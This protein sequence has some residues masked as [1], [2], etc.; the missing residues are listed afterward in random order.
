MTKKI[1]VLMQDSQYHSTA[2]LDVAEAAI[3][4]HDW[5]EEDQF[6]QAK[7]RCDLLTQKYTSEFKIYSLTIEEI[8]G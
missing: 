6:E 2:V 3:E 4:T 7:K 5:Y 8:E 1:Y